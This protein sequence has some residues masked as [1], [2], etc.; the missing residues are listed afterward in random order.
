MRGG[1]RRGAVRAGEKR[2]QP[3]LGRRHAGFGCAQVKAVRPDGG[4]DPGGVAGGIRKG[5]AQGVETALE[6]AGGITRRQ[7]RGGGQSV[8]GWT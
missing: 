1:T 7:G 6:R 8:C 3:E 4:A 2:E 5:G